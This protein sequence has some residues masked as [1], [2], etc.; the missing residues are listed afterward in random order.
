M[1]T[2]LWLTLCYIQVTS[3]MANVESSLLQPICEIKIVLPSSSCIHRLQQMQHSSS[4]P[5]GVLCSDQLP[6]FCLS[7]SVTP[8]L[9]LGQSFFVAMENGLPSPP[10]PKQSPHLWIY[11]YFHLLVACLWIVNVT[12]NLKASNFLWS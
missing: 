6:R 4:F 12:I 2:L 8:Q 1:R 11:G 5:S 7:H 9:L 3:G 10:L